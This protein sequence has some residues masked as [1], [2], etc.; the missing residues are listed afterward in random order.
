MWLLA[1]AVVLLAAPGPAPFIQDVAWSPDGTLLAVSAARGDWDKGGDYDIYVIRPDGSGAKRLTDAAGADMWISWSPDG[2]RIAFN[3]KRDGA[4]EIYVMNADGTSPRRLTKGGGATPSWSPD[5]KRIAFTRK[6]DDVSQI[7]VMSADGGE[8]VALVSTPANAW[9]PMW[10]PDG[11]RI[12]FYSDSEGQG[13]DQ[14]FTVLADGTGLRRVTFGEGNNIFP[15]WSPDGGQIVFGAQ[16]DGK[17][18]IYVI[19]ADGTGERKLQD[20]GYLARFS[21]DGRSIAILDGKWPSSVLSVGKADG[22]DMK[23]LPPL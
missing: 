12:L 3:S 21:P 22:S 11:S 1:A 14:I 19:N 7:F 10:S 4:P 13:K 5:G 2:K 8:A 9:N 20:G 23:A 6:V 18:G 16:R 15:A 17:R